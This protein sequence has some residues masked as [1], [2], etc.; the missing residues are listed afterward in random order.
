[1]FQ[2]LTKRS[3]PEPEKIP[4]REAAK[5]QISPHQRTSI[6][7][8]GIV[9]FHL[10]TGVLFKANRIAARIWEGLVLE[11]TPGAIV[12]GISRE[13]SVPEGR[14]AE[15]TARF[16]MQLEAQGFLLRHRN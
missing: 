5:F 3:R 10:E 12:S 2:F 9:F 6:H 4:W 11:H 8:E 7:P 16:L 14:V 15:D 1:M 13:Y